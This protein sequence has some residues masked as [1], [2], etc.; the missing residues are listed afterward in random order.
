MPCGRATQTTIG[1]V[2]VV[3]KSFVSNEL[4]WGLLMLAVVEQEKKNSIHTISHLQY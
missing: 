3:L 1:I 2:L 4:I